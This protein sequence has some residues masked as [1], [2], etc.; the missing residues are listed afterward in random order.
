MDSIPEL[1]GLDIEKGLTYIADQLALSLKYKEPQHY[2]ES[3]SPD[4][5][6][7]E[8][9]RLEGPLSQLVFKIPKGLNN[10][11]DIF[12]LMVIDD[13]IIHRSNRKNIFDPYMNQIG[14]GI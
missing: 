6:L 11:T 10:I 9:G 13:G 2:F 3:K 4:E 5:H 14:I 12:A 8:I 7:K 1:F